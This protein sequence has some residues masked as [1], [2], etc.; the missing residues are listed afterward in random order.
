MANN[1]FNVLLVICTDGG[2]L[3]LKLALV[4]KLVMKSPF[5]SFPHHRFLIS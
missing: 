3:E 4:A 1:L 5:C 2:S